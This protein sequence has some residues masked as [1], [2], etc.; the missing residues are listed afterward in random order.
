MLN[1][2]AWTTQFSRRH[3]EI[4]DCW[5]ESFNLASFKYDIRYDEKWTRCRST[6][7]NEFDIIY[8]IDATGSMSREI[9]AAKEQV[10]S[11]Y[12]E[13]KNMYKKI[14]FNCGGIFYRDKIDSSSD[15]ND[16]FPLTDNM[17]DLKNKI[18]TVRAYGGGDEA[19][20]W[21]EAYKMAINNISWREGTKLIIHIADA[22]AHGKEFSPYDGHNDQGPLLPPYI[23]KCVEKNIKIIGFKIG[24]GKS[25]TNSFNKLKE[26]YYDFKSEFKDNGQLFDIYEFKRGSTAEI[27]KTFKDLVI[28]AAT[29]AAPKY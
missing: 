8:L 3:V 7:S 10:I 12:N 18:E 13:L 27:S 17:E 29:V 9:N 26:I 20:D 2:I 24:C 19:E 1:I 11:I 23:R 14:N 25:V 22:G 28:K 15:K 5:T 16:F 4:G 21:V 6:M